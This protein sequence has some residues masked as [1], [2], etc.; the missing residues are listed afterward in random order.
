M[1]GAIRSRPAAT[2]V[3]SERD[4]IRAARGSSQREL[5]TGIVQGTGVGADDDHRA[6]DLVISAE[7]RKIGSAGQYQ[8]T[9]GRNDRTAGKREVDALGELYAG[10]IEREA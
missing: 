5:L 10:E 8:I 1:P 7:R 2:V 4:D 9:T 6:I 3:V